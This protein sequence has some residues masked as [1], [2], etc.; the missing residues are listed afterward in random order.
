MV[1]R[2]LQQLLNG[3][4]QSDAVEAK[5]DILTALGDE[6]DESV[7]PVL[8]RHLDDPDQE[9][10]YVT[11][12]ALGRHGNPSAVAELVKAKVFRSASAKVRRAAVNAVGSLGDFRVIEHLVRAT[13]DEEWLVRD[14]AVGELK[15]KV[16][17][18]IEGGDSRSDKI[19]L[20]MLS[21]KDPELVQMAVEGLVIQGEKGI[22]FL[23]RSLKS[24]LPVIREN[25]AK[26]LGLS[27]NS[28]AVPAL[29][30]LLQD[31]M[32]SVRK[33]AVE[34]LGSLRD[35]RAIDS[36]VTTLKDNV[37]EVQKQASA[38]LVDFGLLS[39]EPL[40]Q[41]LTH[42]RNKFVIRSVIL[43]LGEI[44]DPRSI[45]ALMNQIRNPYFLL[46]SATV[47]ALIRFGPRI[48]P[49]LLPH[50][51]PNQTPVD[52]LLKDAVDFNQPPVQL[53]AIRALGALEEHRATKVLKKVIQEG[54]PEVIQAAREAMVQIGTGAWGRCCALLVLKEV[55]DGSIVSR[56]IRTLKD[57]SLNVR[58]EAVRALGKIGGKKAIGPLSTIVRKSRFECLRA[59]AM[60]ELRNAGVGF[61]RALDAAVY[62]LKDGDWNV[63]LHA[64][65]F[66]GNYLDDKSIRP[67]IPLLADAHWCV[68]QVAETAIHNFGKRAFDQL[69]EAL[70]HRSADVRM[71]AASL[72]AEAG[73][74][75]AIPH[76]ENALK[77]KGEKKFVLEAF[78]AALNWPE[79]N[80]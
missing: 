21:L 44:R 71:F 69:V 18:M 61:P 24:T 39:T 64:A 58:L 70:E 48:I 6:K 51:V 78:Q 25:T 11:V 74:A 80:S 14:Q 26:A 66:L 13:E 37:P 3:L 30:D 17:R 55:G 46:R 2:R 7:Y 28:D 40:L 57:D 50:L 31:H 32:S 45:P 15:K 49:D 27:K 63:R 52:G 73:G 8:L 79:P 33:S 20:H 60:H 65:G 76:I 77:R 5:K 56:F 54:K 9:I 43:T 1:N 29:M 75:E 10:Q 38:A 22:D 23:V 59:E 36:L 47:E 68:Q 42:E 34:A 67:L 72:L 62:A 16:Q 12:V 35:K 53:R 4:A 41:A 19:L